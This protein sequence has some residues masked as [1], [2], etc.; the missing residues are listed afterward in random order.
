MTHPSPPKAKFSD[1]PTASTWLLQL[2]ALLPVPSL[3]C[4]LAG[5]PV[6]RALGPILFDIAILFLTYI[7]MIPALLALIALLKLHF[8]GSLM[9]SELRVS[10]EQKKRRSLI[11]LA[12]GIPVFCWL[13]AQAF[14]WL[15]D[16]PLPS[17]ILP[18]TKNAGALFL[19]GIPSLAVSAWEMK[20]KIAKIGKTGLPSPQS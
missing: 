13:Q 18:M 16:R 6:P 11:V 2:V 1:L 10:R 4:L 5:Y 19:A 20:N 3:F 8:Y 7:S 15:T 17:E 14:L 12:V 9:G